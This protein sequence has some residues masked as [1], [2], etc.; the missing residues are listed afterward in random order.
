MEGPEVSV[1]GCCFG[2]QVHVVQITDKLVYADASPVESG[3]TQASRFPSA[4]QRSIHDCAVSGIRAQ[5][6]DNCGFHAEIKVCPGGPRMVEIAAQGRTLTR[7]PTSSRLPIAITTHCR[8]RRGKNLIYQ[9]QF[10]VLNDILLT[11]LRSRKSVFFIGLLLCVQGRQIGV[12][13]RAIH[14]AMRGFADH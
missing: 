10:D 7:S 13:T 2:G 12:H 11:G 4:V 6:L 14:L 9:P 1:E 5:Q 3:H 8:S